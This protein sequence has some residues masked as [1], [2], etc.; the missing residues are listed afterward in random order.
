MSVAKVS[1][2]AAVSR[3]IGRDGL[4]RWIWPFVLAQNVLN[5]LYVALAPSLL[6][7]IFYMRG[8]ELIGPARAKQMIF[9]GARIG[10][11]AC[12]PHGEIAEGKPAVAPAAR[13]WILPAG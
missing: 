9:T 12:A 13:A 4:R 3:L 7:Q 8:V 10:A 11:E 1:S 5:L 2:G 6:S